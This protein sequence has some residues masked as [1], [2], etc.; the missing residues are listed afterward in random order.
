MPKEYDH[1]NVSEPPTPYNS[2]DKGKRRAS[3]RRGEWDD[4]T[5]RSS[6]SRRLALTPGSTRQSTSSGRELVR[7]SEV[8]KPVYS[9]Y[10][11]EILSEE[12]YISNLSDIIKRDFFPQ[13]HSLDTRQ[14]II[15]GLESQDEQV[16]E[17]SVRRMRELCT[18]RATTNDG[19]SRRGGKRND[20]HTPGCT[21]FSVDAPTPTAFDRTPLT[22]F[23]STPEPSSSRRLPPSAPSHID[24][25]LS[26]DAFQSR[27]TSQDNSSFTSLLA[28]DNELRRE[29]TR[30]AWKAEARANKQQIRGRKARER[31]VDVTR[32]LI[33]AGKDGEGDGSVWMLEGGKAGRPGERQVLVG[34]GVEVDEERGLLMV[35]RNEKERLRITGGAQGDQKLIQGPEGGDVKGKGKEVAVRVDEKAKQ[36]VDWDRPAVEEEEANKS[37]EKSNLQV[38]V[39]SW[40]FK[41]RNS[42]M[43]PPDADTDP[44]DPRPASAI[45]TTAD[46]NASTS[47]G[48]VLPLGEPKGIRY[49]ATRLMELEKGG[50]D[51]G[52]DGTPSPTRSRIHAAISGTPYPS[53]ST[54]AVG[55]TPRVNNFSFVSALPSP[56]AHQLPPQALQ[57][58][59]TWGS[60]EATPVTLRS[61]E[62]DQSVGPFRIEDTSRRE[63]LA[64]KLA[65]KAKR[66]LADNDASSG[67]KSGLATD[68][69]GGTS[70][71]R[72]VLDSTRGEG[73]S[74]PRTGDHLSPAARSLLSKTRPGRMLDRGLRGNQ[75]ELSKEDRKREEERRLERAK[76]RAREVESQERLRRERWTPSPAVSLGFDP[77][78]EDQR[79]LP[80]HGR[81][82]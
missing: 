5:P 44:S 30:W 78:L 73:N 24:T 34:K 45:E 50:L 74:T 60:I 47:N 65:R 16:V 35:G 61:T 53:S 29:K 7:A 54:N 40:P 70:L 81:I 8:Y 26:L 52:S 37:I 20:D 64:F 69:R 57:E 28:R 23:S 31:L 46:P 59:M 2:Q 72:G 71:R 21:P 38:G 3:G 32:S 9:K 80:K 56:R 49:H 39:E 18:P 33:E 58:L 41:N 36:Y 66:S 43:F 15:R 82:G 11:Q 19:R 27:Y 51:A 6:S 55:S 63:E 62:V 77:D 14:E 79:F 22:S 12:E 25:S 10:R 67:R 48:P 42:L 17:E 4:D 68:V 75:T 1:S 76:K 13:L